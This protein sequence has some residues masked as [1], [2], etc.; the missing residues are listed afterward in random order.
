MLEH[1]PYDP[2]ALP[3]LP[4]P[5]PGESI[6]VEVA[7]LPPAKDVRASIRNRKHPDHPAFKQLRRSATQA[8]R[9]RAWVSGP[10]S[11]DLTLLGPTK[12]ERWSSG[13]YLGGVMDTLDGSS[14]PTFTYLPIVFEDDC[15]VT[16]ASV[17]WIDAPEYRYRL[18][19]AFL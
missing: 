5:S 3:N 6:E 10:V 14:G 18:T 16:D 12:P 9:G 19:V 7:G 8:M 13:D 4:A 11:L 15:Q 1:L 17:R 2:G